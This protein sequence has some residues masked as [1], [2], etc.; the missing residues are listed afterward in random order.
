MVY[1]LIKQ[2]KTKQKTLNTF[3]DIKSVKEYIKENN[4]TYSY[5]YMFTCVN[6]SNGLSI[7]QEYKGFIVSPEELRKSLEGG[8]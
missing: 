5:P 8:I 2:L 6:L 4:L 1:K 7:K 3:E